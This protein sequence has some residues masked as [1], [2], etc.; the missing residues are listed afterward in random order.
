MGAQIEDE[1]QPVP[2]HPG[3]ALMVADCGDKRRRDFTLGRFC[4]HAALMQLGAAEGA[5]ARGAGGAP[6]WPAAFTGSITHTVGYAAALV[7]RKDSFL[8]VG[9]DAERVGGVTDHLF[10]RLFNTAERAVLAAQ[11]EDRRKLLATILFSAKEAGIKAWSP[12]TGKVLSFQD[13]HV[14]LGEG[15]FR[16]MSGAGELQGCFAVGGG[17][18]LTSAFLPA[19]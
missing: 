2:L 15:G 4:A 16:A 17:L 5:I 6:L 11:A 13:I 10:L 3:E 12:M 8:S 9:V 19:P 18:V 14:E 1:G 7:A